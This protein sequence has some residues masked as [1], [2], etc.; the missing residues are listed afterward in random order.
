MENKETKISSKVVFD[1]KIIKV[2]SDDV[3]LQNGKIT[4]REV[5]HHNGGACILAVDSQGYAYF[6]KQYRYP[7]SECL[8]ELPAGK[9]EQNEQP[10]ATAKRELLEECGLRAKELT[11]LGV[12]Y[13]TVAY[14]TEKI[15]MF[16]ATEFENV[17][18]H[19]DD[20]EFLDIVKIPF[21]EAVD[22]VKNNK[23]F[24]AKTQIAILKVALTRRANDEI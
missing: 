8:L 16:Y 3:R 24:D 21:S 18:Q 1:G 5:V 2:T 4:F 15:Y 13:P 17:S 20:D 7:F 14:C 12:L 19:L 11:S 22:M 9:L 10:E 6:V 23:I